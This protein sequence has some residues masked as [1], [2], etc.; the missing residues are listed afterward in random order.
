[1]DRPERS[2][3]NEVDDPP[4]ACRTSNNLRQLRTSRA[5]VRGKEKSAQSGDSTFAQA[6]Q[7]DADYNGLARRQASGFRPG[8]EVVP[9]ENGAAEIDRHAA[10]LIDAL[11]PAARSAVHDA[12]VRVGSGRCPACLDVEA[13]FAVTVRR[14]RECARK[15]AQVDSRRDAVGV[16]GGQVALARGVE[17]PVL[18]PSELGIRS[19]TAK[20]TRSWWIGIAEVSPAR[21]TNVVSVPVEPS[22][23]LP[24]V[25]AKATAPSA[26][27]VVTALETPSS[28]SSNG[29]AASMRTGSRRRG[30]RPAAAGREEPPLD[31]APRAWAS[32]SNQ[33]RR[34]SPEAQGGCCWSS[35]GDR[36]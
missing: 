29:V 4:V 10:A 13:T 32:P 24:S 15:H 26:A 2:A 21:R 17:Q 33:A 1:M 36:A 12:G 22:A 9:F 28:A 5:H 30:G 7:R 34:L 25:A 35:S 23:A 8:G 27:S 20:S 3:I 31:P 19:H 14:L 6:R 18:V 11:A 16:K